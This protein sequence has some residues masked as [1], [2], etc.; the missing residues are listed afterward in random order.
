MKCL[1]APFRQRAAGTWSCIAGSPV[2]LGMLVRLGF[3]GISAIKEHMEVVHTSVKV[4]DYKVGSCLLT[5]QIKTNITVSISEGSQLASPEQTSPKKAKV[6]CDVSANF[7]LT[8][9]KTHFPTTG[10]QL[11]QVLR[12]YLV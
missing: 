9:F 1:A 10:E 8:G 11:I 3:V 12:Y 4:E 6:E 2:S 5:V 7:E